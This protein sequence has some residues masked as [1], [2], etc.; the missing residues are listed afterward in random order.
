MPVS[1]LQRN[2]LNLNLSI[3]VIDRG[4]LINFTSCT[5]I[6]VI[7]FLRNSQLAVCQESDITR[8]TKFFANYCSIVIAEAIR[9]L[10]TIKTVLWKK[11]TNLR[12]KMKRNPLTWPVQAMLVVEQE[13]TTTSSNKEQPQ[14]FSR[15][16]P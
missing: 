4:S 7:I 13:T 16:K 3:D 15:K 14:I 5:C 6:V 10:M 8:T 1:P 12:L 9:R 11:Q 2:Q